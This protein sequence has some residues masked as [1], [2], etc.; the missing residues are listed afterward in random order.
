MVEQFNQKGVDILAVYYC[1]H[2]PVN[3]N[4]P[5]LM[6]CNCRKPQPGM[7]LQAISDHKLS[8]NHSIM[9]GDKASDMQAAK[10]A[11]IQHK[12]LVESGQSFTSATTELADNVFTDLSTTATSL[13]ST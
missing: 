2:H 7:L 10:A 6:E 11:G 5:Y 3:A 1:P 12:Y 13:L 8:L 4:A 9:V